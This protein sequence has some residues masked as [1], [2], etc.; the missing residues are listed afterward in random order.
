MKI[1]AGI[2]II[3][4]VACCPL[5]VPA[6]GEKVQANVFDEANVLFEKGE[7]N[8]ALRKYQRALKELGDYSEIY[9]N[10]GNSYVALRKKGL[11]K[12]NYLRALRRDPR[13]NELRKNILILNE[14]IKNE[15]ETKTSRILSFYRNIFSY[16]TSFEFKVILYS[17]VFLCFL[18][19]FSR[20]V[21]PGWKWMKFFS[22]FFPILLGGMLLSSGINEILVA[23]GKRAVV[24]KESV[25][26]Y[27]GPSKDELRK[28]QLLDGNEVFVMDAREYWSRIALLNRILN[29]RKGFLN[30]GVIGNLKPFI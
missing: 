5:A 17:L 4:M 30:T 7:I 15:N 29:R 18:S 2:V 6:K 23:G 10:M 14:F 28:L 21:L 25:P 24:L 19:F 20:L 1:S 8:E 3:F 27:A 13:N 11:A 26:L 12:L 9:F 22:V 16:F